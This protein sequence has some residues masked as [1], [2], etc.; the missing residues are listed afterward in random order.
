MNAEP[1]APANESAV[2]TAHL[3]WVMLLGPALIFVFG[4]LS[5]R[6]KG[7]A[8]LALMAIG[9]FWG[10][11]SL[12]TYRRSEIALAVDRVHIQTGFLLKRNYD[13]FLKEIVAIDLYQPSLGAML[14]FGKLIIVHGKGTRTVVRMVASPIEFVMELKR[15]T[16]RL[17]GQE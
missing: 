16:G 9:A 10:L 14:N 12:M 1:Q 4:G 15:R 3:H 13:I 7:V 5:L 17:R 11:L 2:L 6:S 8:A